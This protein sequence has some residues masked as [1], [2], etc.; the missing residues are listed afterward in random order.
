MKKFRKGKKL[1]NRRL[2]GPTDKTDSLILEINAHPEI[3]GFKADECFLSQ[4]HSKYDSKT[5]KSN[6]ESLV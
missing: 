5:C 6:F 3:Y 4:K 1:K 2:N